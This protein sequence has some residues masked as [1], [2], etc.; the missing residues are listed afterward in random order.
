MHLKEP[1]LIG[2]FLIVEDEVEGVDVHGA[3]HEP[4][5]RH[6]EELH[7]HH[8]R[9][10]NELVL[11]TVSIRGKKKKK[12]KKKKKNNNNNNNNNNNIETSREKDGG[13]L[14]GWLILMN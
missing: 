14:V 3:A 8:P 4:T 7:P 5:E 9:A 1:Y 2:V 6:E 11:R 10:H 13:W 12:K